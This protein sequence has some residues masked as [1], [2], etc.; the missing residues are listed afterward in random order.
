[1]TRAMLMTVLAR[2]DG[3]STE[4]GSTWYEKG[5]T[6][7]TGKGITD[8]TAPQ[9]DITREQM[10]VMLYRYAGSPAAGGS[11]N[12][13][14]DSGK[15]SSWARVAMEW[16]VSQGIIAGKEGR[17]LDPKGSATRAEVAVV[18][19]LYCKMIEAEQAESNP[20]H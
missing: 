4:G 20:N 9:S 15:V 14:A 5:V 13:F 1:M 10:V 7:A 18:I 19:S 6:W 2:L 8:G 16:A 12:R 17:Q 11:L 3:Q